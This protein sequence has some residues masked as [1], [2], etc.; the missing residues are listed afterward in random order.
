MDGILE[1]ARDAGSMF[2]QAL[3]ERERKMVAFY[4]LYLAASAWSVWSAR[5]RE[6]SKVELVDAV[7]ERLTVGGSR[8]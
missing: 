1:K 5:R 6:R 7:V 4:L 8:G 2:W 3:D